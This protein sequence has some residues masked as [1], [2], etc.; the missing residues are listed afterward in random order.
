MT[1]N[2]WRQ[3]EETLLKGV[4]SI[5]RVDLLIDGYKVTIIRNHLKGL[6]DCL[7]VFVNGEWKGEWLFK[8]CEIRRR[9]FCENRKQLPDVTSF[10]VGH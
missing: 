6:Q 7:S 3:V 10:F 2:D 8:D 5:A 4:A 9:F 1:K